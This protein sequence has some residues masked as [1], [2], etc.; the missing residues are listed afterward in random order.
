LFVQLEAEASVSKELAAS[1]PAS[2]LLSGSGGSALDDKF[3]ALEG[4][5]SVDDE[6]LAMKRA[7]PG[8]PGVDDEL[9]KMRELMAT[10]DA[11]K[12]Q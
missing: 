2:P 11:K 12:E 6:L 9:A 10:D 5:S 3:K 7:L 4:G 1:S 8:A